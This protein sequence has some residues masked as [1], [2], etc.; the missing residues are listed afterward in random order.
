MEITQNQILNITLMPSQPFVAVD[1]FPVV[2]CDGWYTTKMFR[3]F[4][5]DFPDLEKL[6]ELRHIGKGVGVD[7]KTYERFKPS[8][9]TDKQTLY[10]FVHNF[11]N[12]NGNDE[13][14]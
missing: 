10:D 13:S 2:Y 5:E 8:T 9:N 7:K 4:V 3:M 11:I 6:K 12:E 1:A 14:D